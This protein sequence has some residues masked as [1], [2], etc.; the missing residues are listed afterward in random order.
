MISRSFPRRCTVFYS[1]LSAKSPSIFTATTTT[2]PLIR[3]AMATRSYAEAIDR[4]NSLQSNAAT[5]EA[6]RASGGRL[7][8]FAIPEMVEYLGRIG[9]QVSAT[10]RK[11]RCNRFEEGSFVE[12]LVAAAAAAA[13]TVA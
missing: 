11:T 9:Y 3:R 8:D 12:K 1:F 6:V 4:L 2:T 10:I 5:L 7:S 13:A